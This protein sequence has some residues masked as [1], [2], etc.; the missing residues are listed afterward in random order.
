MDDR[1]PLVPRS[2]T[3]VDDGTEEAMS[4]YVERVAAVVRHNVLFQQIYPDTTFLISGW[5]LK[6]KFGSVAG[7]CLGPSIRGPLQVPLMDRAASNSAAASG[8]GA[9]TSAT[10]DSQAQGH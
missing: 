9:H 4:D 10:W 6:T 1:P 5:S 7:L 3:K 2:Y 8:S